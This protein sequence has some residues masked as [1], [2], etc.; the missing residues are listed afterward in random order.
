MRGLDAAAVGV[1]LFG[2]FAVALPQQGARFDIEARQ[3]C[4]ASGFDPR[5]QSGG[6]C[7]GAAGDKARFRRVQALQGDQSR[8]LFR[9]GAFKSR[10]VG[11]Q[12][13]IERP[14]RRF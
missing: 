8:D 7:P 6:R 10:A 9:P 11:E 2:R 4:G 5:R 3:G 1:D 14:R 12:R 13:Q